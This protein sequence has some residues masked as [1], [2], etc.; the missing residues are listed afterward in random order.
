MNLFENDSKSK[1]KKDPNKKLSKV[2]SKTNLIMKED[3][4]FKKSPEELEREY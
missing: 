4:R 1:F 2:G 3:E